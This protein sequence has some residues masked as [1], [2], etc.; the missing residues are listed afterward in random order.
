MCRKQPSSR[1]SRSWWPRLKPE[2]VGSIVRTKT[3]AVTPMNP[4]EAIEQMELLG[5][6]FFVFYNSDDQ[7]HQRAV[8]PP[9]GRLRFAAAG[10]RLVRLIR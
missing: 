7:R 8:S 3:F 5:H 10:T 4:E 6:D 9:H 1:G 2:P